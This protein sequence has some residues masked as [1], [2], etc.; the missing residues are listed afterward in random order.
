MNHNQSPP[1]PR[2][3]TFYAGGTIDSNNLGGQN[4]EGTLWDFPDKN[5]SASGVGTE[6]TSRTVRCMVVRNVGAAAILPKRTVTFQL[7]AGKPFT[8]RVDGMTRL[9]AARGYPIDEYLPAAGVPVN[10]L[11]YIVISGPAMCLNAL[12]NHSADIA[13]GDRLVAITGATS[14]ATT[15]GRLQPIDLT[16]ATALLGDQVANFVGRAMSTALTN[17]GHADLL[18]DVGRW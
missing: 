10:D 12:S 17:A 15:A 16:G 2:G 4:L 11:C 7:T 6:R 8:G 3:S 9:T 13:V 1:F 5:D 18:V 14:G